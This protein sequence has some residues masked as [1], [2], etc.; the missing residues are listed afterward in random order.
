M[1]Y[2]NATPSVKKLFSQS[3]FIFQRKSNLNNNKSTRTFLKK[4]PQLTFQI[5]NVPIINCLSDVMCLLE[6]S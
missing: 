2:K 5:T 3:M 6:K 4:I 1:L